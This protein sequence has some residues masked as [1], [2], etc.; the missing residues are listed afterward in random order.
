MKIN[1]HFFSSSILNSDDNQINLKPGDTF[2]AEIINIVDDVLTLKISSGE[3]LKAITTDLATKKT[4]KNHISNVEKFI[5]TKI[6]KNNI[7]IILDSDNEIKKNRVSV[8]TST[9]KLFFSTSDKEDNRILLDAMIK[10]QIPLTEDIFK[11]IFNIRKCYNK[12]SDLYHLIQSNEIHSKMNVDGL[13]KK[14]MLDPSIKTNQLENTSLDNT[15]NKEILKNVSYYQLAFLYKNKINFTIDNLRLLNNLFLGK[16][17]ITDQIKSLFNNISFIDK[18][19]KHIMSFVKTLISDNI[20]KNEFKSIYD[21]ILR[22]LDKVKSNNIKDSIISNV[23]ENKINDLKISIDFINKL[24][25]NLVFLQIPLF[26]NNELYNF[27]ILSNR[28]NKKSI[29]NENYKILISLDTNN[30]ERVSVLIDIDKSTISLNFRILS[31]FVKNIIV[32]KEVILSEKIK[33]VGFKRVNINYKVDTLPKDNLEF[34]HSIQETNN[35]NK[36]DLRV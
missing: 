21:V 20:N 13:I 5:I 29:F 7:F 16:N 27:E 23:I 19:N 22:E 36:I 18:N 17:S 32:K 8:L 26:I 15:D 1:P 12:L 25:Q 30:L 24:N 31:D 11:Y 6:E 28:K 33:K 34:W 35:K 14:I 9:S 3:I 2:R 10:N 4:I